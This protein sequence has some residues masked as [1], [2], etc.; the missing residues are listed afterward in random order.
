MKGRTMSNDKNSNMTERDR[1]DFLAKVKSCRYKTA[2]LVDGNGFVSIIES[3][4][5]DFGA[6]PAA[7]FA[8]YFCGQFQIWTESDLKNFCF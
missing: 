8:G 4:V 7:A 5:C 3:A 2:E 1:A 6:G